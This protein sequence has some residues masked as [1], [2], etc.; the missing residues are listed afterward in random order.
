LAGLCEEG[1]RVK[2]VKIEKNYKMKEGFL[3]TTSPL[4][5]FTEDNDELPSNLYEPICFIRKIE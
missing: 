2:I 3:L 4:F 5:I 1:K